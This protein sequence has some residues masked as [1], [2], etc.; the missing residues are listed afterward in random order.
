MVRKMEKLALNEKFRKSLG[1]DAR[2]CA[3]KVHDWKVT[4]DRLEKIF[5]NLEV[6]DRSTTWDKPPSIEWI[7]PESPPAQLNDQDFDPNFA[8]SYDVFEETHG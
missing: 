2:K 5:D 3:E 8:I 4:T 7:P 1:R 6:L